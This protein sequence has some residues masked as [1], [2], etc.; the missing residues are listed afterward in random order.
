MFRAMKMYY[1]H[2]GGWG[3]TIE[4]VLGIIGIVC[5]ALGALLCNFWDLPELFFAFGIAAWCYPFMSLIFIKWPAGYMLEK[6]N[7]YALRE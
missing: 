1:P 7:D 4:K 5:F 2:L 6:D 3:Y